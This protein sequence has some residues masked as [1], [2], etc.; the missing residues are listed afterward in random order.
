MKI[1]KIALMIALFTSGL[2]AMDTIS[3]QTGEDWFVAS[4]INGSAYNT[5]DG[6]NSLKEANELED[7]EGIIDTSASYLTNTYQLAKAMLK[8]LVSIFYVVP[9]IEALFNFSSM[10]VHMGTIVG[11][12]I[13]AVLLIIYGISIYQLLRDAG[14]KYYW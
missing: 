9:M 13:N 7:D 1:I 8:I 3:A 14:I 5:S 4:P 11:T 12:V 6:W 2:S 10:T